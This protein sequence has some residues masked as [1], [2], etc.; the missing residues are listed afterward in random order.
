M[1]SSYR[2]MQDY[3]FSGILTLGTILGTSRQPFSIV[4]NPLYDNEPEE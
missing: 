1:H 3:D 4:N 2:R